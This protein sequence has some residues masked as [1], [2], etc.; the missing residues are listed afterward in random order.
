MIVLPKEKPILKNLNTYY[1][2]LRKLFEHYQGEIG[3]GG[4]FFKA[5]AAEGVIFFDK[6]ELLNGYFRDKNSKIT[7]QSA[8]MRLLEAKSDYNFII[9][10]YRIAQEEVY[11]WASLPS[12]EKIY[13]DLS[14]EFTDLEKL[15]TKMGSEKLTGFIDVSIGNDNLGGLIF[16]SNGKIIGGSFSWDLD[17]STP[18]EKNVEM[19]VN[20]TKKSGGIFQVSRIPIKNHQ[21]DN[22]IN[23]V[24][25]E[26]SSDVIKMLEEYLGVFDTVFSSKKNIA[27]DFNKALRKKFVEKAEQYTFL[28]PFAAEFEYSDGKITFTGES[29]DQDLVSGVVESVQELAEEMGLTVELNN[30]MGSWL[31]K[32]ANK[33]SG[34]EISF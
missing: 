19:L 13:Q 11:F 32:Y 21:T 31:E 27:L 15:I 12:A 34:L 6:D 18:S 7:G 17:E 5:S 28:D 4:I 1:L 3:S 8:I 29:G 25:Y 14:T 30:Y 22:E 26:I 20:K 2:D 33:L 23:E 24:R 9:D 10:I 16:M